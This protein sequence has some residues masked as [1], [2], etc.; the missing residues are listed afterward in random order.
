M[1][2][3]DPTQLFES[4][5]LLFYFSLPVAARDSA[6]WQQID[7]WLQLEKPSE[8]ASPLVGDLSSY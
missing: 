5:W 1:H 8:A 7:R 4:Q 2:N 3:P 6:G